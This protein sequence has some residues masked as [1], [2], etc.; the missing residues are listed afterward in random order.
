MTK[1]L[2][3]IDLLDWSSV[4]LCCYAILKDDIKKLDLWLIAPKGATPVNQISATDWQIAVQRDNVISIT[5]RQ[6][7]NVDSL[8][9]VR[10]FLIK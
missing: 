6:S 10:Y 2:I 9:Q 3:K 4:G 7:N 8:N 1:L 5:L